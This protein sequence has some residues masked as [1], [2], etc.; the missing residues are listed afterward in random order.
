MTWI[1]TVS[2]AEAAG[3]VKEHYQKDLD[4]LGFV[5]EGTKVWSLRP[6]LAAAKR[7]LEAAI[8]AAPGLSLR[9]QRLIQLVVA[10]RVRSTG[11]VFFYASALER[12]LSGLRGVRAVLRDYRAAG[13]SEREVAILDYALAVAVGHPTEAGVARLRALGLDDGA[14][15]DVAA[16]AAYRLFGSRVYDALGV[17]A[18]PFFLEQAD[19]VEVVAPGEM[20]HP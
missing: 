8:A 17:G 2:E 6:Q 12:E 16:T 1:R 20:A 3:P 11:C 18:D 19:L 4:T 15:L 7:A 5:L 13:L 10:Q 9:E 14:I